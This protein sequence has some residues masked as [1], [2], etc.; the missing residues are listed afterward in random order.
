MQN[1]DAV[2]HSVFSHLMLA[3][4][5]A[6]PLGRFCFAL[7]F[8]LAVLLIN[9]DI[10]TLLLALFGSVLLL[11]F[12]HSTWQPIF[13]AARLLLWLLIP[14]FILHLMFTPGQLIWPGSVLP[15]SREGL[16]E[17]AW[18][19][20]HLCT[21]FYAAMLLSGSLSSEEWALY[22]LRLPWIGPK[23]LPYVKLAPPIRALA[24]R[25]LADAKRELRT[26]GGL[27]DIPQVLF[28]LTGLIAGLWHASATE[29]E[30]VWQSWDETIEP[31]PMHARP[32]PGML[33][34]LCGLLLPLAVWM[35]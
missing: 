27:S 14:I 20:L 18:L 35:G 12:R 29:A 28:A 13:R 2:K 8:F 6:H 4:S 9:R 23:L 31:K 1:R 7:G 33:L 10:S 19:A 21:L 22:C 34:A 11:R 25:G 16:F 26:A 15:F 32:V 24:S 30:L 5:Q 3:C 17:G